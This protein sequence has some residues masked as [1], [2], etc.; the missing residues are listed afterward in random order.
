[1]KISLLL[2]FCL[3]AIATS[4]AKF[5]VKPNSVGVQQGF[6]NYPAPHRLGP[7]RRSLRKREAEA[8][9]EAEPEVDPEA[10]GRAEPEPVAEPAARPEPQAAA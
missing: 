7:I 1:M 4:D 2:I 3:I 6:V 8:A 10:E 9:P 5:V